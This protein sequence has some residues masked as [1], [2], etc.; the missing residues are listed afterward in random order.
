MPVAVRNAAASAGP[1]TATYAV[2]TIVRGAARN[3]AAAV[4]VVPVAPRN[5]V[6]AVAPLG[7]KNA[8]ATEVPT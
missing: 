4:Q 8:A 7:A 6:A 1:E 3:A 2:A 5:Y